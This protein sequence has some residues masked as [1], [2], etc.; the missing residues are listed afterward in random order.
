MCKGVFETPRRRHLHFLYMVILCLKKLKRKTKKQPHH[1]TEENP[2]LGK[3]ISAAALFRTLLY[4]DRTLSSGASFLYLLKVL[5]LTL[6]TLPHR[7]AAPSATRAELA[8]DV[9]LA[10]SLH[11]TV[12]PDG[13]LG[14]F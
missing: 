4:M 12:A 9:S 8:A 14:T 10:Q 7:T 11:H 5:A 13:S 6:L 3:E 1:I 2:K